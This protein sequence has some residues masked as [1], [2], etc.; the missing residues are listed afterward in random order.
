MSIRNSNDGT[1]SKP[2]LRIDLNQGNLLDLPAWSIGPQ[3]SDPNVLERLRRDGFEGV[4]GWNPEQAKNAGLRGATASHRINEVGEIEPVA[5]RLKDEGFDLCTL[6]VGWGTED[7]HTVDALVNDVINIS[8]KHDFP[9]YLE[10]HRATIAQ[11]NWRT[12]E[13][14]KRNPDVRFNADL[15]HFYTGH[16]MPY[17]DF[18][19]KVDFLQPIFDRTCFIHGR[20]GNSSNMQ[21]RWNDP[22]MDASREHFSLMWIR[23][24]SAWKATA[25]PGDYFCFTP[26]IIPFRYGYVRLF[27]DSTGELREESDRYADALEMVKLAK[28]CW[29]KA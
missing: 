13:L 2:Y 4:Q 26:E 27:A 19:A 7:D 11:D 6:H 28:E 23:I 16:E 22:S 24:F 3:L 21:V 12:V 8:V 9:L 1:Q 17:G 18:A 25:Q 5:M 20:I 10:T 15:S 14:V 29:A